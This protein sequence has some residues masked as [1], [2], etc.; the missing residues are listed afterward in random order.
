M[1]KPLPIGTCN[2]SL[3]LTR[4]ERAIWG[5]VSNENQA[6][7]NAFLQ[8]CAQEGLKKFYPE[9]AA[10]IE[11]IRRAR[12]MVV[13]IAKS[14]VAVVLVGLM[15]LAGSS[16]RLGSRPKTVRRNEVEFIFA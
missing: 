10:E 9:L 3:N 15:A 1:T 8:E 14:A 6:S 4:E 5:R 11:K 16:A 12:G 2:T 7:L 13:H